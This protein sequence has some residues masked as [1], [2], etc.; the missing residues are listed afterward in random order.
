MKWMIKAAW[1]SYA[2]NV[3]PKDAPEI[4]RQECRKVFYAGAAA[5]FSSIM[6]GIP[7]RDD[8][9]EAIGV[10]LLLDL[11]DELDGFAKEMGIEAKTYGGRWGVQ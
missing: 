10:V 8:E 3:L 6:N 9:Q 4:Q 11:Q 1:E 5:L 2:A 7:D